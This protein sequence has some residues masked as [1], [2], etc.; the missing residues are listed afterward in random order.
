MWL[1]E[2]QKG[3]APQYVFECK[4]CDTRIVRP[5]EKEAA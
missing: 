2:V 3:P 4:V 1:V 5:A